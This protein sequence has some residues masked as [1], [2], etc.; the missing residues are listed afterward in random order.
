MRTCLK[1]K[2]NIKSLTAVPSNFYNYLVP[3]LVMFITK[4]SNYE[5][6]QKAQL[7]GLRRWLNR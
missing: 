3:S 4:I 5:V 2:T 1:N 7:M 6:Q